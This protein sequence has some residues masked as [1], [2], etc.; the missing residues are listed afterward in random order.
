ML[1]IFENLLAFS[2]DEVKP[3]LTIDMS[4]KTDNGNTY[5]IDKIENIEKI[6]KIEIN[7]HVHLAPPANS[8]PVVA[9]KTPNSTQQ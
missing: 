4:A 6:E 5:N 9:D 8:K 7:L 3:T 1:N 2:N